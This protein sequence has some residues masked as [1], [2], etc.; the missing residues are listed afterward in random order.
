[1]KVYFPFFNLG[2]SFKSGKVGQSGA[3]SGKWA[4]FQISKSQISESKISKF[5]SE[6]RVP[7]NLVLF[8]GWDVMNLEF[9]GKGAIFS[10]ILGLD[11][12]KI[13]VLCKDIFQF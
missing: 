3:K 2:N 11:R 9:F 12:L 1:M 6:H 13:R 10:D 5:Q 4:K 7:G 8:R